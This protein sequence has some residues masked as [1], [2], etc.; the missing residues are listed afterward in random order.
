MYRER[1]RERVA[2]V[3]D[4]DV[5]YGDFPWEP[6]MAQNY[7]PMCHHTEINVI[8][9]YTYISS[10]LIPCHPPPPIIS[11]YLFGFGLSFMCEPSSSTYTNILIKLS[12]IFFGGS[13]SYTP[14]YLTLHMEYC[15]HT[16]NGTHITL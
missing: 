14:S 13:T 11:K 2:F 8:H 6:M 4:D 15:T 7:T 5:Q 12:E 3:D 10:S 1:E 16:Q 9:K